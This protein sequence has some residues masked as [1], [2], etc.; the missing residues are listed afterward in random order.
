[1]SYDA[2]MDY[3]DGHVCEYVDQLKQLVALPSI[4]AG[5]DEDSTEALGAAA[6]FMVDHLQGCGLEATAIDVVAG[7]NPLVVAEPAEIAAG[8]PTVLIYGHYDVQGVDNPRSAWKH[9]PFAAIEES[10]CLVGRGSSDNKG[11]CFAHVKA[12]EAILKSGGELPVN[13]V[14]LIEGEEECG[15]HAIGHFVRSGALERFAP[16]LCTVV[17]DTSMYGPDQPA[18]T[19]GLRGIFMLELT[20]RGANRDLHSGLYGGIAPNPNI[21]LVQALGALYDEQ[22]HIAVPGF[23]DDVR[24]LSSQEKERYD[25]LA[26]DEESYCREIGVSSLSGAGRYSILERRWTRPTLDIN[27][28]EG[29]SPRTVLPARARAAVSARL[30]PDQVP[31]K[32]GAAVRQTIAD[33]VPENLALEYGTEHASPAYGLDFEH[34]LVEPALNALRAGFDREPV[35]IREGGSIPIVTEFADHT[36]AP[37]LLLGL[38]QMTDNWHGP[39]ERF[40]L[41]DFHRGIRMAAALLHELAAFNS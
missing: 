31:E 24:E 33:H 38:G 13:P 34:P 3:V 40:S 2:V 22:G 8:K 29:G 26:Q 17:S 7:S 30:V 39:N 9:D 25:R 16:V 15:S 19:L 37:V 36:N 18:L 41:K 1:V 5:A 32:I 35:L 12:V 10:G 28:L 21:A 23:F 6:A 14:F 4:S 11:P 27:L 20:I